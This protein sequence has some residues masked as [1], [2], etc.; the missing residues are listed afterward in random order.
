LP[1]APASATAGHASKR[2]RGKQGKLPKKKKRNVSGEFPAWTLQDRCLGLLRQWIRAGP[3]RQ[4]FR[5]RRE[6]LSV[7]GDLLPA[8]PL[9]GRLIAACHFAPP[10]VEWFYVVGV[11]FIPGISGPWK[12]HNSRC[13]RSRSQRSRK[14]SKPLSQGCNTGIPNATVFHPFSLGSAWVGGR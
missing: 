5:S 2:L 14:R 11:T 4:V 10:G 7:P 8:H 1:N 13:P 3:A 9:S 6:Y 12:T